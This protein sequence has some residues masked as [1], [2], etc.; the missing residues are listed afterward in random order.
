MTAL[1]DTITGPASMP[2][3][4]CKARKASLLSRGAHTED[5]RVHDG[6]TWSLHTEVAAVCGPARLPGPLALRRKCSAAAT[7]RQCG[8]P[9][10]N[11]ISRR[12]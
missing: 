3:S 7:R 2:P 11:P 9:S 1:T 10:S 8:R 6:G 5:Q 12:G 4:G